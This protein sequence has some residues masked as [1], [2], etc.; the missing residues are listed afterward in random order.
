MGEIKIPDLLTPEVVQAI[1]S[2]AESL[3]TLFNTNGENTIFNDKH[4]PECCCPDFLKFKFIL[5]NVVIIN[6][7]AVCRED[8]K[9]DDEK[10]DDKKYF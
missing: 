9:H 3:K 8:K 4:C 7:N 6:K 1:A 5:C 2:N 10:D